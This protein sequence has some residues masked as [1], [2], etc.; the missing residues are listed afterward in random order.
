VIGAIPLA[1]GTILAGYMPSIRDAALR[2][3]DEQR[4]AEAAQERW[5]AV[6]EPTAGI[7][8]RGPAALLRPDNAIV[9]FTGRES[10]LALLRAWCTSEDAH[11]VRI[12]VGAGGVG[13]TRLALAVANEWEARGHEW[14]RV[15]AGQEADAVTAARGVTSGPVLLVVDY[16]ETRADLESMFRAVLADPSPMRVLLVARSLGE[17]WDRLKEK[18]AYAIGRLLT[19]TKPIFLADQVSQEASSARLVADAVPQF[20]R[21]LGSAGPVPV[22]FEV[23]PHPVPILV[24]HTAALIAVLRFS[25][26][27]ARPLSVVVGEGLLDE[28]LEHESRYWRR[29]AAAVGLAEDGALLKA[30][31]A[32]A[33]LLGA[34][35][36]ADAAEVITRVPDLSDSTQAQLRS[37]ARW[38]YELYPADPEGRL[39]SLR[40]DLLAETHVVN[41][42]SAAP[43]LARASLIN[44]PGT[45]AEHALTVLVRASAHRDA[46][47][48]LIAGALRDDLPHLALPAALVALQ[49]PGALASLLTAALQTAPAPRDLLIGIAD[50][51]PYPSVALAEAQL[52]VTQR[53]LDS[54]SSDADR[55]LVADWSEKTGRMLAQLGRSA[56]A[57]SISEDAVAIYRDLVHA[58]PDTY[59]PAL[60]S[61]LS[62]LG[63]RLYDQ[64]RATEAISV[65]E[66]AIAI[67]Q[68]LAEVDPDRYRPDLAASLS[69]LGVRLWALGRSAEAVP[70]AEAT[71][72]TFRELA[73]VNPE[74]YRSYLAASQANLGIWRSVL[75]RSAEALPPIEE[76]AGTYRELAEASPDRY[77]P[78]LAQILLNLGL[79]LAAAGRA[80]DAVPV[81]EEAVTMYREL[82]DSSPDRFRPGLAASLANLGPK[83]AET[84]RSV[85]AV[86]VMEE[87]VSV[88]RIL[89]EVNPDRYSA[90]LAASLANLGGRL[91]ETGRSSDSLP[92]SEEAVT[93]FRHLADRSPDRYR[94]DLA[95]SLS[96]LGLRLL[97]MGRATDALPIAEEGTAILR[98]LAAADPDRYNSDFARSL[99]N[100]A[101]ILTALNQHLAAEQARETANKLTGQ[102]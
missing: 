33:A 36:L 1:L 97:E 63:V 18:S 76:A 94:A 91:S 12:I 26:D 72:A 4:A 48:R 77:R 96:N 22:Q 85:D 8:H 90:D 13:K 59:R 70:I 11:S 44:L 92:P 34:D 28:L 99:Y 81:M 32:L 45:K 60:A 54:L 37:W 78:E 79:I 65:T 15:D 27:P 7:V 102:S 55:A 87:A 89:A 29:K 86:T 61:A 47:Q 51:M 42:L 20:A 19:Q 68:E 39:G 23:P 24:L 5:A 73:V 38:L 88:H 49:T 46:A 74:R 2:R 25:D 98:E 9:E 31:T 3:R 80:A 93:I 41:Q 64:G 17:W 14:R 52:A 16:A 40:P 75:G 57:L 71:V 10:E 66:E 56:E 101:M 30:V 43:E 67:G 82:A 69:N 100:Q 50:A 6:G 84:G 35:D 95:A 83:L 53:V 21:A 62:T 58:N